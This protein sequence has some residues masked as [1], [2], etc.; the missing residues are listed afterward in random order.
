MKIS[1]ADL[2]DGIH[3][4]DFE[5]PVGSIELPNRDF[6]PETIFL[7]LFV[8]RLESLFRF[9]FNLKT[10][11]RYICDRCLKEFESHF[12]EQSE[13][14]YQLGHSDLDSDEEIQLLPENTK[15]IDLTK[16]IQDTFFMSRPI[17]V[18]CRADCKGLCPH[19]GVNLNDES[20]QCDEKTI[21]PRLQKLRSF[22]SE[23]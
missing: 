3:E 18:L 4:F 11:T 8:D 21:D 7:H 2:H 19:C 1:I 10:G 9:K 17:K 15:E 13:Q 22:L 6:Y 14:L 5:I 12:D 20:C 16:A 23:E